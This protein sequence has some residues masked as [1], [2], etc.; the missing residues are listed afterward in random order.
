MNKLLA[1]TALCAVTSGAAFAA[2]HSDTV[3]I[4]VLLGYTGPIESLAPL[5][6]DAAELA[7]S[8][9]NASGTF[10]DGAMIEP[11]RADST[12]TDASAA[13]AAAALLLKTQAPRGPWRKHFR[14]FLRF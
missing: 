14:S 11:V 7:I 8:E 4:G 3:K 2:S 5:M 10:M 6:A 12:C 1:A 9:I 13:T